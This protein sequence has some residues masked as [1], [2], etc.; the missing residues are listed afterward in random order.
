MISYRSTWLGA[1]LC[2][3][4]LGCGP[5]TSTIGGGNSDG[6]G[7]NSGCIAV[8]EIC[9]G[10]DN[11]CD[12]QIDEGYDLDSDTYTSCNGDCNDSDPAVHP[13]GTEVLNSRDD[14]CDGKIDNRID[15]HDFDQDGTAYPADCNDDEALVGPF[16]IEAPGDGVD[17]NCNGQVDEAT[18]T[19]CD[20]QATSTTAADFA[21]AIGVCE[22]LIAAEFNSGSANSS[23]AIRAKF[24]SSWTPKQGSKM[25][26]LSS[27]RAR[28]NFDD[29]SYLPQTGHEYN[30]SAN[31][32]LYSPPRCEAPTS[33]PDANDMSELKLTLKV[34]QNAKSLSYQFNFFS[35]EYPEFVCTEFNDRYIAILESSGLDTSKLPAGQCRSAVTRPTCNISYDSQGQPVSINNGFFDVCES[36]SGT[37]WSNTCTQPTSLLDKTGYDNTTYSG[38]LMG[39]ATGWLVTKAPVTPGETITLRFIVFDE[40]DFQYDSAVLIDNFKWDVATVGAPITDPGIN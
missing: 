7:N 32:P 2:V 36:S 5:G 30:T 8:A 40:G 39:G 6:G 15:G 11:D 26:M 17:N 37:G 14:D 22:N 9:D 10:Q 25:I 34:P 29:P 19:D 33:Q 18:A 16:A 1:A 38:A 21:R 28:D 3:V 23:R 24:G 20:A 12:G 13:Y 35:A 4:G 27:G 31:H